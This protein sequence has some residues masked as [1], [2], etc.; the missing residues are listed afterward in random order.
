MMNRRLRAVFRRAVEMRLG[1]G[2]YLL[3]GYNGRVLTG[4]VSFTV[5]TRIS[6][7]CDHFLLEIEDDGDEGQAGQDRQHLQPG[8]PHRLRRERLGHCGR[9]PRPDDLSGGGREP[10]ILLGHED[11][12]FADTAGHEDGPHRV[13]GGRLLRH[14]LP[15]EP[16]AAREGAGGRGGG[17]GADPRRDDMRVRGI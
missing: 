5:T 10:M 12:G 11:E 6:A 4:D 3:D 15:V 14:E 13:P 9:L 8:L 7:S 2:R 1:G 16:T 17:P